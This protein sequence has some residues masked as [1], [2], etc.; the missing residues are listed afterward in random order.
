VPGNGGG[1]Y[2]AQFD[3]TLRYLGAGSGGL[4]YY[5]TNPQSNT[6][7]TSGTGAGVSTLSSPA[8]TAGTSNSGG[9]GGSTYG[10]T[11]GAGGSGLVII[12]YPISPI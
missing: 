5:N 4:G 10:T 8:P 12:K 9:A 6:I 2:V 7:G 1:A 11:S 3:G